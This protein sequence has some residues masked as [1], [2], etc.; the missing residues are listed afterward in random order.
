MRSIKNSSTSFGVHQI[1]SF[2]RSKN[3][4]LG[5][6]WSRCL[7][8]LTQAP[9]GKSLTSTW[10]KHWRAL[11]SRDTTQESCEIQLK[12]LWQYL[13][14]QRCLQNPAR[15]KW[16]NRSKHQLL[17][18]HQRL[19][20][21]ITGIWKPT[22]HS[23]L[24]LTSSEID[25]PFPSTKRPYRKGTRRQMPALMQPLTLRAMEVEVIY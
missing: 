15:S 6:R 8:T 25:F 22:R 10:I 4:S 23:T 16:I 12:R 11:A 14:P 13:S 9:L 17:W 1:S 2:Y 5:C 18:W 21:M 19:T 20:Q 24:G 7:C 3:S